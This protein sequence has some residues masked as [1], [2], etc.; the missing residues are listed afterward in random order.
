M[1]LSNINHLKLLIDRES[2]V[3]T[4]IIYSLQTIR[5]VIESIALCY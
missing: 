4:H 5:L 1:G 3:P 2:N